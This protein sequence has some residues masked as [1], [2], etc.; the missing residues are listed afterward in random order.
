MSFL[1]AWY[2]WKSLYCAGSRTGQST[3]YKWP[4]MELSKP[5]CSSHDNRLEMRA[6]SKHLISYQVSRQDI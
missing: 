6:T 3:L 1:S 4:E 5:D 2:Y